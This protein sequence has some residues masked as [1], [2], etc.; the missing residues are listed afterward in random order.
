MPRPGGVP[1]GRGLLFWRK[2]TADKPVLK[3]SAAP[4]ASLWEK[5]KAPG[6]KA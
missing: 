4:K 3:L 2:P 6:E 5:L 1:W